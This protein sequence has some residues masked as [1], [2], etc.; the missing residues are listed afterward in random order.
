[1]AHRQQVLRLYRTILRGAK[2]W[3]GPASERKDIVEEAS[4]LF[5]KN[6]DV[7]EGQ[8]PEYLF[9]AET[10][11]ELAKHYKIPYARLYYAPKRTEGNADSIRANY[12]Q[13]AY[14]ASY[15]LDH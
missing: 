15:H 2:N 7:P 14:R 10:R 3:D 8:V 11:I 13:G 9:E 5:R 12:I 1:M 4:L 6:R